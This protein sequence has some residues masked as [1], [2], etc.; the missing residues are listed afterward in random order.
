MVTHQLQVRCRPVKVRRSETDVLPLS[1]PTETPGVVNYGLAAGNTGGDVMPSV[2]NSGMAVGD[3]DDVMV[4]DVINSGLATDD[5]EGVVVTDVVNMGTGDQHGLPGGIVATAPGGVNNGQP[6]WAHS[7]AAVRDP[8]MFQLVNNGGSGLVNDDG[9]GLASVEAPGMVTADIGRV[10]EFVT[11]DPSN[12]VVS[13]QSGNV[14]GWSTVPAGFRDRSQRYTRD[15]TGDGVGP[16]RYTSGHDD[17]R[18]QVEDMVRQHPRATSTQPAELAVPG[19]ESTTRRHDDDTAI[20]GDPTSAQ[21][22]RA[23]P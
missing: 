1:H 12:I 19:D 13:G 16:E 14:N 22:R 17:D 2:V 8:G 15:H 11:S 6:G 23:Q 21:H 4:T 3:P 5:R 10:N 20:A 7:D 18:D 9:S